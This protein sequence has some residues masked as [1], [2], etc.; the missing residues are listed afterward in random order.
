MAIVTEYMHAYG[1]SDRIVES[2]LK[3]Y[4]NA[5]IFSATFVPK[6]YPHLKNRVNVL[7][8]FQWFFNTSFGKRF[9][10]LFPI[11]F[12][13]FDLRGYDLVISISAGPSKGV[14]TMVDQPHIGI[15][16]TPPRHQWDREI[17]V[18]GSLLGWLYRFGSKFLSNYVRIWDVTATK[19]VD[20]IVSIS[21]FIKEK[22]WKVY[23][24]S[25]EIIYPGIIDFWFE[26]PKKD[27]IIA[28]KEQFSLPRNFNLVVTRLY[29][30]KKVDIAIEACLE[31]GQNLV[32]AGQG[33][34]M[35]YLKKIAQKGKPGQITFVGHSSDIQSRVLYNLADTFLFCGIEDFGL[36]VAEAMAGGCPVI[37]YNKGGASESVI[38]GESGYLYNTY[39]ELVTMLRNKE[40]RKIDPKWC[41]MRAQ[42]F[43]ERKFTSEL[44]EYIKKVYEK[45]RLN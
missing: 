5:D 25:S 35:G 38:H 22:V 14:I 17:N 21:Q 10:A 2:I 8:F 24:R 11:V 16:C 3:I 19:R 40:W 27:E 4:P 43:T 20:Y 33:P 28:L 44:K 45:E 13:Q 7:P 23:R 34:D 32:I 12:E 26:K 9:T 29:D 42:K 30:Y 36:V 1:G 31:T 15:I 39:E 37:A 6:N 18:R 41:I